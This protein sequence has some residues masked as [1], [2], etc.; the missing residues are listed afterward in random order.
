[1]N[2]RIDFSRRGCS[3][4]EIIRITGSDVYLDPNFTSFT[5]QL[6]VI[7]IQG[8]NPV[9][10]I[11][12]SSGSRLILPC[13]TV[14]LYYTDVSGG[15][16]IITSG[17]PI[18]VIDNCRFYGSYLEAQLF[19]NS[20]PLTISNTL[21]RDNYVD[22]THNWYGAGIKSTDKGV[23]LFNVQHFL[24]LTALNAVSTFNAV[25]TLNV[26]YYI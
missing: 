23:H 2:S 10:A 19:W 6:P 8:A 14:N 24:V 1:M 16:G 25:S 20:S 4:K 5:S 17:Q 12:I 18:F 21:I 13:D 3:Y 11:H 22:V 15:G 7:G 26:I 9:N